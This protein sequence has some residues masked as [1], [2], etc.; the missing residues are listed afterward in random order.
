[1]RRQVDAKEAKQAVR[2]DTNAR[3]VSIVAEVRAFQFAL[4]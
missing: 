1:M 3:D 4:N 2:F